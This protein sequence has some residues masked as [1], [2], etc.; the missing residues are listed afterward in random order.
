MSEDEAKAIEIKLISEWNTQNPDFGYN[1]CAGGEGVTGW[2]PTAETREKIGKAHRGQYGDKNPNYGH[3]WTDEMKMSASKRKRGTMSADTR[4]KMSEAAKERVGDKNP[5]FGKRHTAE[6]KEKISKARSRAVV[7]LDKSMAVL[8]TYPSI[9][10]ASES[11]G[12]NKVA[13]S[14]C[15]RGVTKTSGG[16]VWQYA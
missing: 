6:T 7:M 9:K 1:I 10:A 13:I 11:T 15:C 8:N 4:R 14:N 2:H 12:I 3:K 5:F 16:F